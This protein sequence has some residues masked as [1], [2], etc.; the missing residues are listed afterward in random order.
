MVSSFSC[1]H[2]S[3][4]LLIVKP[5]FRSLIS[6]SILLFKT[7]LFHLTTYH[8]QCALQPNFIPRCQLYFF[9]INLRILVKAIQSSLSPLFLPPFSQFFPLN[10]LQKYQNSYLVLTTHSFFIFDIFRL[11]VSSTTFFFYPSIKPILHFHRSPSIMITSLPSN[12]SHT[13]Y[14]SMPLLA[15]FSH[16]FFPIFMCHRTFPDTIIFTLYFCTSVTAMVLTI[17]VVFHHL[18][19]ILQLSFFNLHF[20]IECHPFQSPF[21]SSSKLQ[22]PPI[23]LIMFFLPLGL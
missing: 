8:S 15:D 11:S 16:R 19:V 2:L 5:F 17:A 13:Y 14:H 7:I 22:S 12:L 18:H 6:R 20:T 10:P 3:F 21:L 4:L 1:S 23:Y 9:S